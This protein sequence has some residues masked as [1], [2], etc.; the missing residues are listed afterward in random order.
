MC[1]LQLLTGPASVLQVRSSRLWLCSFSVMSVTMVGAPCPPSTPTGTRVL[2][3]QTLEGPGIASS[4]LNLKVMSPLSLQMSSP[5]HRLFRICAC[6][7]EEINHHVIIRKIIL[8]VFLLHARSP[9]Y[10][11]FLIS[12]LTNTLPFSKL[13]CKFFSGKSDHGGLLAKGKGTC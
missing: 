7:P 5:C 13:P 4:E 10:K 3:H 9:V 11:V 6:F 8:L 1:H 2:E 12:C